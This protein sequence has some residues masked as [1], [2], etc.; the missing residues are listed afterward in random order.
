VINRPITVTATA[1]RGAPAPDCHSAF[2]VDDVP[3]AGFDHVAVQH[4]LGYPHAGARLAPRAPRGD[5]F[6]GEF[7]RARSLN[8]VINS[9][10][11]RQP[12]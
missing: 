2:S 4:A 10:G 5:R 11:R 7:L 12:R 1:R 8:V 3:V 9:D 6:G